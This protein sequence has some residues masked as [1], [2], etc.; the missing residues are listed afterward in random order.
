MEPHEYEDAGSYYATLRVRDNDHGDSE[1]VQ[2][3]I[4]VTEAV[5]QVA[6]DYSWWVVILLLLVILLLVLVVLGL[7]WRLVTQREEL[8]EPPPMEE[9]ESE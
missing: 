2:V 5:D 8:E 1:V 4:T 9:G 3:R 7:Q 6:E